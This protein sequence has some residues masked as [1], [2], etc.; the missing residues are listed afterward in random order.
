[1]SNEID[2]DRIKKINAE[3]MLYKLRTQRQFVQELV[4]LNDQKVNE[5]L[6]RFNIE[7]WNDA[8]KCW[9]PSGN[10]TAPSEMPRQ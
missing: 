9:L 7:V 6:L 8:R 2:Q 10:T 1:M 3:K 5:I 4:N